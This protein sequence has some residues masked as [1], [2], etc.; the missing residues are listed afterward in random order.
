MDD[1]LKRMKIQVDELTRS[2]DE[3]AGVRN[4]L[5]QENAELQRQVSAL[6]GNLDAF[7]KNKSQAQLKL[8]STQT[9][10]EEEIR[11]RNTSLLYS[12]STR[13]SVTMYFFVAVRMT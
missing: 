4:K 6:E 2:R 7:N 8:E 11:V 5:T 12:T 9:K 3:M 10:L 13:L 1:Q